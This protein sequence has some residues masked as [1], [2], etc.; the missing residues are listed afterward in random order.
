VC[1]FHL[2]GHSVIDAGSQTLLIDDHGSAVSAAV[3]ELYLTALE[4]FG[5][6]PTLIEWDNDL[7][8]L[9]TLLEEAAKA[10]RLIEAYAQSPFVGCV[11]QD[12][13]R[14]RVGNSIVNVVPCPSSL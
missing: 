1:E 8:T 14:G 11:N 7:P 13:G 5:A 3:W 2:A 12:V 9:D 10:R 4:R 6:H